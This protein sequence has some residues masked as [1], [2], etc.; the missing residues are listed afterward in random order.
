MV[1]PPGT[2]QRGLRG[3]DG[4]EPAQPADCGCPRGYP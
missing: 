4:D 2:K 1:S 3:L